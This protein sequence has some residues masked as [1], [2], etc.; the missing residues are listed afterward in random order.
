MFT[1]LATVVLV[2][3]N[4]IG[5]T[6]LLEPIG[7]N[8]QSLKPAFIEDGGGEFADLEVFD[9]DAYVEALFED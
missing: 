3:N 2:Q 4:G 1:G 7:Q 6:C 8:G 5:A 9:P